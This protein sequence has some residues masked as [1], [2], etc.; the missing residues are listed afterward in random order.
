MAFGIRWFV[1]FEGFRGAG[2]YRTVLTSIFSPYVSQKSKTLK[3][4]TLLPFK[5]RCTFKLNSPYFITAIDPLNLNSGPWH[6]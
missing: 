3:Y 5:R 4:K 6:S 1:N 2:L